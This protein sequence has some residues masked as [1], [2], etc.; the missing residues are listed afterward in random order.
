MFFHFFFQIFFFSKNYFSYISLFIILFKFSFFN[1]IFPLF[2]FTSFF[3]FFYLLQ[4][5]FLSFFFLSLSFS[6]LFPLLFAVF[7]SPSILLSSPFP[8]LYFFIFFS[9]FHPVYVFYLF[10]FPLLSFHL[11][12]HFSNFCFTSSSLSFLIIPVFALSWVWDLISFSFLFPIIPFISHC[13]FMIK[14]FS[15]SP[16]YIYF[17]FLP[18]SFSSSSSSHVSSLTFHFLINQYFIS[19]SFSY[20]LSFLIP[21]FALIL[22]FFS[23]YPLLHFVSFTFPFYILLFPLLKY[24]LYLTSF[25]RFFILYFPRVSILLILPFKSNLGEC[26]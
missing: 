26:F 8:I 12:F 17:S 18:L 2:L 24:F 9:Y 1:M 14:F 21:Y 16:S 25:S 6:L 13:V 23:L 5:S 4:P 19:F 11:F 7:L 22:S 20:I 15:L 10:F 3:F